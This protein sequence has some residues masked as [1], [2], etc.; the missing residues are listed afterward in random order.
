MRSSARPDR[1]VLYPPAGRGAVGGKKRFC[2]MGGRMICS[3]AG[4]APRGGSTN[5]A[6]TG[7]R[8]RSAPRAAV[9]RSNQWKAKR[10][11][12]AGVCGAGRETKMRDRP[13]VSNI[14][15][16]AGVG[17]GEASLVHRWDTEL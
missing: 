15:I 12:A 4:A 17:G 9:H 14:G 5:T 13:A 7:Q 10:E 3:V 6:E 1:S 2:G 8:S 16:S 11:C